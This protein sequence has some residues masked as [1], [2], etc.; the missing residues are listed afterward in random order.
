[1]T[2][3]DVPSLIVVMVFKIKKE[4]IVGWL[5]V[6]IQSINIETLKVYIDFLSKVLFTAIHI[7]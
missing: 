5:N 3:S 2:C 6:F 1:M 7:Q 4:H